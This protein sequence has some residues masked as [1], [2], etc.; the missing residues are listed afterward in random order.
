M[1]LGI[2]VEDPAV[3]PVVRTNAD[4]LRNRVGMVRLRTDFGR[5][6]GDRVGHFSRSFLATSLSAGSCP[7]VGVP[8]R[9]IP[10][11]LKGRT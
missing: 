8:S 9:V 7:A 2:E 5:Q 6:R 4:G 3:S 11:T 1:V 10:H